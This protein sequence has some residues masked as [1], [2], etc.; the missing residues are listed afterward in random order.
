MRKGSTKQPRHRFPV[1]ESHH[2]AKL[3]EDDVRLLRQAKE[4]HDELKA[5]ADAYSAARMAEF[6]GIHVD[7]VRRIWRGENWS[8]VS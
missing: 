5:Q 6:T 1:G 2:R 8:H 3:T 4:R 7:V